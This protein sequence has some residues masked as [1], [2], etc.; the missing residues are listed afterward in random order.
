MGRFETR[1]GSVNP[2][3]EQNRKLLSAYQ[4]ILLKIVKGEIVEKEQLQR[5]KVE[6]CKKY[7]LEK[8]PS[9]SEILACAPD[10]VCDIVEPFLRL[11][12]TRTA[13][14]VAVVAAMTSPHDC[15]HGKCFYCPGGV[16]FGSAQSYTGKEPAALRAE[17]HD[18]DPFGQTRARLSQLRAIGHPTDKIDLII[19]GGTFT[20]RP[21][22][23]Q[24]WF[25]KRC[26]DA[27]NGSGSADRGVGESD[28]G[29]LEEA[30]AANEI[31][32]SRCI[33]MTVETRPDYFKEEHVNHSL[34]LGATRVELGIQTVFDDILN[35]VERGHDTGKSIAAT[36]F[37]KDGGLK[38]GYHLMPNLPGMTFDKDIEA[39]KRIFESPG[40]MPDM[41]KIYPT[42][43]VKGTKLYEMWK[44]GEY[45][46]YDL[47][48]MIKL[49]A[50]IKQLVPPWVRIQRVQRDIPA[51]MIE[52]GVKK[53]HLRQL[54]QER[55]GRSGRRCNCIR[56][57][58]VGLLWLKEGIE[59]DEER[60]GLKRIEY[61]ASGGLEIFL[62]FE[63]QGNNA[64]IGYARLRKPSDSVFRPEMLEKSPVVIRELKVFGQM[65]PI[66]W[67]ENGGESN[68]NRRERKRSEK[69]QHRGYGR[70]LLA[71]CERIAVEEWDAKRLLVT[72]GVGARRYYAGLGFKKIG[73]YMGKELDNQGI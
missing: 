2:E 38:V 19:M 55:L 35:L 49:V 43:V 70:N 68:E 15:P 23:Y 47:D 73:V 11:K 4:E 61:E 29:S 31:A 8:L 66:G 36:R 5:V 46:P 57:R 14:G 67:S 40:F 26:L 3:G 37:A 62:S 39:F 59:I 12:P 13:S 7:G 58:E 63:D 60:V 56:C 69:W 22:E 42:L 48:T 21:P 34:V 27:M 20:A 6:V 1:E 44:R 41:I 65:A 17:Q 25:V 72:S 16:E 51:F 24:R 28:S 50:E 32:E 45:E 54:A 9:N 18:F 53:S 71:E 64:L 52:D 30:Q 10:D 33:G